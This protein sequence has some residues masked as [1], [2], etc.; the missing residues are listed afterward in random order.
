MALNAS[1]CRGERKTTRKK[2][3]REKFE[4]LSQECWL[5]KNIIQQL[6]CREET[7]SGF[8]AEFFLL[9]RRHDD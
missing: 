9:S 1:T 8:C 3:F 2:N 6:S 7:K 5:Y 4:I